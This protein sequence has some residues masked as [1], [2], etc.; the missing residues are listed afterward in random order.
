MPM[1]ILRDASTVLAAQTGGS[2]RKPQQK[3]RE[4]TERLQLPT[5][6]QSPSQGTNDEQIEP[7]NEA[8]GGLRHITD[9]P[10][11]HCHRG[12][13]RSRQSRRG[14]QTGRPQSKRKK[15]CW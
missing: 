8:G 15:R 7:E 11:S 6:S 5:K 14:C 10:G 3:E 12:V 2:N 4:N 13:H 1:K 9:H